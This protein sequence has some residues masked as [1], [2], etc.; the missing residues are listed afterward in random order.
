MHARWKKNPLQSNESYASDK[1]FVAAFHAL[2]RVEVFQEA[3]SCLHAQRAS[4]V[5]ECY[6]SSSAEPGVL[7]DAEGARKALVWKLARVHI[8]GGDF[9]EKGKF[10][11]RTRA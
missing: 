11:A 5:H 2:A 9:L 10:R 8:V 1:R 4:S 3:A 7:A 6:S